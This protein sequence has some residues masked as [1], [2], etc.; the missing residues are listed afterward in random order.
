PPP[1]DDEAPA[2]ADAPRVAA[3]LAVPRGGRVRRDLPTR[4]DGLPELDGP[5]V[6]GARADELGRPPELSR[7]PARLGVP[8]RRLED[9]RVHTNHRGFRVRARARYRPRRQLELQ[10]TRCHARDH[11][12]AVGDPD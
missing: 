1:P 10:G 2:P 8:E 9:D 11:A 12:R 7:P 6:P 5:G 4:E 3:A